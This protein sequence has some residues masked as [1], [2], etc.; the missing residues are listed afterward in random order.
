MKVHW[1]TYNHCLF[2][3]CLTS[4]AFRCEWISD[5]KFL[6]FWIRIGYEYSKNLSDMDQELKNQYPLTSAYS[7][8]FAGKSL[9]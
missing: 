2:A 4:I 9:R 6:K 3:L 8:H 7:I 1:W 5:I